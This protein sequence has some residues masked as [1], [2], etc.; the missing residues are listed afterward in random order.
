MPGLRIM[1]PH[2]EGSPIMKDISN[3]DLLERI[4]IL[5][6]SAYGLTK[7]SPLNPISRFHAE[8]LAKLESEARSRN[9]K[10]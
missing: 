10:I 9:L 8:T 6:S 4:R 2:E 1:A 7:N 5:R 3:A